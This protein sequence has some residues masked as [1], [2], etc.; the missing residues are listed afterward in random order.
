MYL[1]DVAPNPPLV[2][3]D[4][5][6]SNIGSIGENIQFN[7]SVVPL[8]GQPP[9]T[10]H[11]DFG[12][13]SSST[14]LNPTHIYTKAGVYTYT[15]TVTD[16]AG[17]TDR[18]TGTITINQPMQYTPN[19]AYCPTDSTSNRITI[20][21]ADANIRWDDITIT[22]NPVNNWALWT[23][24]GITNEGVNTYPNNAAVTV[25]AG[26]YLFLYG[27]SVGNVR[28]TLRYEPTNS[29]LGTWTINV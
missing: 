19:I 17:N 28:V 29:L 9:Y 20:R 6:A 25:I 26:D 23:G 27:T 11:W 12:D 2:I 4:A 22:T 7:G 5:Y 3:Y 14:Q 8:T 21:S 10:Y 16:Q 1:S 24:G 15:F 13:Q 18:E